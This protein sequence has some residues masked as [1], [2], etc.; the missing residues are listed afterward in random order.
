MKGRCV[1]RNCSRKKPRRASSS[2][3]RV[4]TKST[5][6][7]YSR[8]VFRRPRLKWKAN[9]DYAGER[10]I[11]DQ[12]AARGKNPQRHPGHVLVSL[13]SL[14]E[15][16][17]AFCAGHHILFAPFVFCLRPRRLEKARHQQADAAGVFEIARLLDSLRCLPALTGKKTERNCLSFD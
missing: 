16:F 8:Q 5:G 1:R 6:S 14:T 7:F 3:A 17:R 11:H 12:T 9:P 2:L 13:A 15:N 10:R 4:T